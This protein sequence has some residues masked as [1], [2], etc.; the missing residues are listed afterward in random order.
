MLALL[1]NTTLLA[2]DV[3]TTT[4]ETEKDKMKK[5]RCTPRLPPHLQIGAPG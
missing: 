2:K 5:T 3:K 1:D 4:A